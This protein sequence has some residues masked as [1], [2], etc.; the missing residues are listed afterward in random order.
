MGNIVVV[1][2]VSSPQRLFE[3]PKVKNV[4]ANDVRRPVWSPFNESRPLRPTIVLRLDH[5]AHTIDS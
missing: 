2:V 4:N 1:V 3:L 5:L